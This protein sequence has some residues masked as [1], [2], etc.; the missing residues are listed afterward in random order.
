M[1]EYEKF[2]KEYAEFVGSKYAI[3]VSSGTAALHLSLVA[4]GIGKGD[5]V[6][7]PNFTMAACGFAVLYTGATPIFVDCGD[8]LNIAPQLIEQAITPRTKAIMPVHIYGRLCYMEWINE[9]AKDYGL[10]VIE[11]ACEAQ[12]ATLG[13]ATLT[14]HSLYRN[15]IVC[16]EE[17]G[18]ITTDN[19]WLAEQ[20]RDLRSMSFGTRHNYFHARL[21][22]NYRLS[23]AHAS[24]ARDSLKKVKTNL[25]KR[26]QIADWYDKHLDRESEHDVVWVYDI[27]DDYNLRQKALRFVE[28]AREFFKPLDTMPPFESSNYV[29]ERNA[30]YYGDNGFYLPVNPDMTEKDVIDIVSKIKV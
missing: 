27:Q 25:K 18:V 10:Y 7:V 8:D 6:I 5:E 29:E 19:E 11:D 15:K 22:F 12:G 9:I 1:Q 17:G 24:I 21:G 16:S 2:E 26:Q 4:L 3:G 23:N 28:G 30:Q 20:L 14:C 13:P